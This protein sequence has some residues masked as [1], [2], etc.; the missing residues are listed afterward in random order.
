MR[1][2]LLILLVSLVALAPGEAS[3]RRELMAA[4]NAREQAGG[5]GG[6][7]DV[8][9]SLRGWYKFDDGSGTTAV[10]SSG[11]GA[12]G[13][14]EGSTLPT[15]TT[16]HISGAL[17]FGNTD[18]SVNLGAT[19]LGTGDKTVSL[20]VNIDNLGNGVFAGETQFILYGSSDGRIKMTGNGGVTVAETP[21]AS[22]ATGSWHFLAVS[23]TSAG[24]A[25]FYINGSLSG[26]ANQASGTPTTS[27]FDFE[28]GNCISGAAQDCKMDD[29]RIYNRI[30]SAA[31]VLQIY[32]FY[33]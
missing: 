13:T 6:G 15:W 1:A 16:G 21:I 10:N 17:D 31:E 32:N 12:N 14:L 18:S 11:A 24:T 5:G 19:Y 25:N 20:W 3:R 9:D 33:P 8:T 2:L 4:N 26:S 23:V 22:V 30:L 7:G 29:V 28:I 27:P